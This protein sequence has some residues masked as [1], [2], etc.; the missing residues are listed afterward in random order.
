MAAA[1]LLAGCGGSATPDDVAALACDAQVKQ[2]LGGKPYT[3][4]L[5][6][7][8]ANKSEDARG[9]QLLK[10]KIVVNAGLADETTQDL[11][12]TVR[13]SA[14]GASAEVMDIRF[15]W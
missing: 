12:C 9:G 2:Q 11:E 3:L 8:A 1:L 13:M 10:S 7:L 15:I 5:A 14:D 6:S 4:D